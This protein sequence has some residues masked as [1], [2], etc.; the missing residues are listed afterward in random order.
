MIGEVGQLLIRSGY[1]VKVLNTINFSKSMKYNPLWAVLLLK[2]C[3]CC[4]LGGS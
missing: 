4:D 2:A 3:A 1:R